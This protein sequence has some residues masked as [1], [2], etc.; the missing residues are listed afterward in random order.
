MSEEVEEVE[1]KVN[2][3]EPL[4]VVVEKTGEGKFR[5]YEKNLKPHQRR[6]ITK[7]NVHVS[8]KNFPVVA[9]QLQ[10]LQDV[11]S[12]LK[13]SVIGKAL[14]RYIP[15]E[16]KLSAQEETELE[17]VGDRLIR[18]I[19]MVEKMLRIYEKHTDFSY[20]FS[21]ALGHDWKKERSNWKKY[22]ESLTSAIKNLE[23]QVFPIQEL[24]EIS[25]LD[26]FNRIGPRLLKRLKDVRNE[27]SGAEDLG[28][29][30]C[31]ALDTKGAMR[32]TTDIEKL[33]A[34]YRKTEMER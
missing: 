27:V 30:R 16:L 6:K 14:R 20:N 3:E 22:H 17:T 12:K 31:L 33:I 29:L 11:E 1:I 5:E 18:I 13:S 21:Q 23:T 7:G 32:F 26:L 15:E 25:S 10:Y 4:V 28:T 24:Q 9:L 2:E 19:K 8:L 34:E